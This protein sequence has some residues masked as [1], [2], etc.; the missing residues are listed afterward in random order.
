VEDDEAKKWKPI[1]ILVDG[2]NKIKKVSK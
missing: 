1:C 2:K